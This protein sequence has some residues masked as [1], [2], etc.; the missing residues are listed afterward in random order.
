MA[1]GGSHS[2]ALK[3]TGEIY[4]WGSNSS[5]QLALGDARDRPSP[6]LQPGTI[7]TAIAAG[8]YTSLHQNGLGE[9]FVA[10]RNMH[11]ELGLGDTTIRFSWAY[12]GNLWQT[13]GLSC[14]GLHSLFLDSYGSLLASGQGTEGQLGTGS[15]S[16]TLLPV[17]V[18]SPDPVIAM[19]GG[20]YHTV[21]LTAPRVRLASI[22]VSPKTVKSGAA[23]TGTVTLNAVAGPGGQ[24][25]YL[26]FY[27]QDQNG[28]YVDGATM[29]DYVDVAPT[30]KTAT[31]PITTKKVTVKTTTY[32]YGWLNQS[33]TATLTSTP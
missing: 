10:G 6:T 18:Q 26:S 25:V 4:A 15:L 27:S 9:V 12:N 23:V 11:G 22:A 5:G 28:A 16:N 31:F 33:L 13:T 1:A 32:V 19:A 8:E 2:L 30:S 20:S 21:F 17:L 14:G 7:A 24:R 3:C 29:P